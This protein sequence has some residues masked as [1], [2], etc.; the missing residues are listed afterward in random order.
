MREARQ[1]G[2]G[3]GP[4][5]VPTQPEVL[6]SD[7]ASSPDTEGPPLLRHCPCRLASGLTSAGPGGGIL[8]CGGAGRG[9]AVSPRCRSRL[10]TRPRSRPRWPRL[11]PSP[12]GL[13]RDTAV[14]HL[15]AAGTAQRAEPAGSRGK[16]IRR[17]RRP[18]NMPP[19]WRPP[20]AALSSQAPVARGS[21]RLPDSWGAGTPGVQGRGGPSSQERRPGLLLPCWAVTP[22]PGGHHVGRLCRGSGLLSGW[23]GRRRHGGRAEG[24][25]SHPP[26][27]L[28][29]HFST[30]PGPILTTPG[31]RLPPAQTCTVPQPDSTSEPVA[32]CCRSGDRSEPS[33]LPFPR[34]LRETTETPLKVGRGGRKVTRSFGWVE[35]LA[36]KRLLNLLQLNENQFKDNSKKTGN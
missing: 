5:G 10:Q 6:R 20:E 25:I 35:K 22:A 26:L 29:Q 3:E 32:I 33:D 1:A 30:T 27:S 7:Q 2:C 14:T 34:H 4:H 24:S 11:G 8:G 16:Q 12:A 19:C 23:A 28:W 17:P 21:C 15:L 13:S 36:P 31:G 9:P 18:W